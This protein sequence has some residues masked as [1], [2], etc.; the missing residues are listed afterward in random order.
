[1]PYAPAD[2]H[3]SFTLHP[4]HHPGV[5]ATTSGPT[6]DAARS[7]LHDLGFR[8]TGPDTM[9]LARIDREEPYYADRAANELARYGFT[10]DI[11]PALQEEINTGWTWA[12]YPMPWC[13]PE[14]IRQVSADAQ[15]IHDDIATGRLTIH[16]HAHNGHT[17]VAVGTYASG[18]RRHVHLHGEGHLRQVTT[19]FETEA[20]AVADFHSHHTGAVRPGPAPLTELEQRVRQALR[21]TTVPATPEAPAPP[22]P[23]AAGP[24]EHEQFL[25]QFL[26]SKPEW[27]KHRTWSDETTIAMHESLS[28]RAEFDHEARHRTDIAWTIAGYDGPVG[29]LLWRATLT[30]DTPIP[31]LQAITGHLD[32]PVPAPG[33]D[34]TCHYTKPDGARS[35]TLP[36]PRGKPP[37]AASRSNTTRPHK[38]TAGPS[39]EA[40][41]Q[42][43]PPG[44]SVCRQAHPTTSW[45]S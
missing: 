22:T 37:T 27:S 20:E 44:Q 25:D 45:P 5:L 34:R 15:R 42:T 24:G 13:T 21:S 39:S 31:L 11:A 12:D 38:T 3:V 9:V 17:T 8:S 32:H 1:M 18:V 19:T 10:V 29:E 6:S 26:D 33:T 14:E 2:A 35:A 40:T 16:L 30:A 41:T 7:H 36:A 4:D 23:V 43:A 28:I